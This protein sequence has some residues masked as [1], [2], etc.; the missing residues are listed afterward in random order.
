MLA[1]TAHSFSILCSSHCGL[2]DSDQSI[3]TKGLQLN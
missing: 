2:T 3:S 1:Q